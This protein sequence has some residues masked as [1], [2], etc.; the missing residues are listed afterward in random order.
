MEQLLKRVA[1]VYTKSRS[2]GSQQGKS[3][4]G[5]ACAPAVFDIDDRT[6]CM[7]RIVKSRGLR[8][9]QE[10][11]LGERVLVETIAAPHMSLP[12]GGS[13]G[14]PAQKPHCAWPLRAF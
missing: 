8:D 12:K 6:F 3:L 1:P 7:S 14:R 11:R 13:E 5:L 9:K 10:R 4:T 2:E